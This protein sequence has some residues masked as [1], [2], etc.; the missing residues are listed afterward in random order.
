MQK[1]NLVINVLCVLTVAS[2]LGA[3]DSLARDVKIGGKV[4]VFS[5]L[6]LIFSVFICKDGI[7]KLALFNTVLVPI[8]LAVLLAIIGGNLLFFKSTE[9]SGGSCE[10][11]TPLGYV[12]M[13]VMLTQPLLSSI[14]KEEKNFFPFLTSVISAAVLSGFAALYLAV[15]PKECLLSDIPILYLVGGSAWAYYL[16]AAMILAGIVTTLVGSL[17][18]LL[19]VI[20]GK[21]HGVWIVMVC[22][23]SFMVSRLGF[24]VIVDKI[25]PALC[26]ASAVYYPVIFCVL[27][28][29]ARIKARRRTSEPQERRVKSYSSLQGRV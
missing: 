27:P 29:N 17:Y 1:C 6:L 13:N 26:V 10:V 2:M 16:V 15:L 28:L 5:V 18:P 11:F 20:E 4:P 19:G 3:T 21:F 9:V 23:L 14:K 22:L 24:Y 8:M 7:G 12:C 25:Y